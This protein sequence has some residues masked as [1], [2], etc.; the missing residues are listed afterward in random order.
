MTISS[1]SW[2]Y[3]P[4]TA[5]CAPVPVASGTGCSAHELPPS[6]LRITSQHWQV[7]PHPRVAK[8]AGLAGSATASTD[9]TSSGVSIGLTQAEAGA[10]GE[11]TAR[12]STLAPGVEAALKWLAPDPPSQTPRAPT[13]TPPPAADA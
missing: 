7:R 6:V 10:G 8:D 1:V 5:R 3:P 4:A 9:T 11:T 2:G 13:A 12:P